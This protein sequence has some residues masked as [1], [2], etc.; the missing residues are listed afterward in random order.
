MAFKVIETQ[1]ELDRIIG[2]RLTREREQND[3]KY[4]GFSEAQE[5]AKKYDELLAK[6]L[7]GQIKKLSD[8]LAAEREKHSTT[9][10]TIADLTA[11]ATKAESSVLKSRIAHEAGL[12]YELADRLTGDD[13]DALRDDAKTLSEFIRPNNAPPLRTNDPSGGGNTRESAT[14]AALAALANSLNNNS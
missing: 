4:A 3:K 5:K 14:Q 11:R 10:K 12:P 2:E 7:E 13:E 9:D 6:D 8:D 1:E